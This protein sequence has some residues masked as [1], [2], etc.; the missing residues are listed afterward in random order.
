MKGIDCM[1]CNNAL[2]SQRYFLVSV[3]ET[4]KFH[5]NM[6]GHEDMNNK[7]SSAIKG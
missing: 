1:R 6:P 3:S 2:L 4:Q 5:V 7:V